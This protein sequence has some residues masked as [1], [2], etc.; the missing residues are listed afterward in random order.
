MHA[1]LWTH[2]FVYSYVFCVFV[3][4]KWRWAF[5]IISNTMYVVLIS[6][7]H[8]SCGEYEFYQ[9]D[10]ILDPIVGPIVDPIV[11]TMVDPMGGPNCGPIFKIIGP[12]LFWSYFC[13]FCYQNKLG[14]K[15]GPSILKI[16]STVL[17]DGVENNWVHPLKNGSKIGSIH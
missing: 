11:D 4:T 15:L 5:A 3:K 6:W 1:Q 10:P 12:N 2:L 16:G 14:P 13:S 8:I 7:L 9:V 17:V